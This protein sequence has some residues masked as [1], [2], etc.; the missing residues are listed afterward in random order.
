MFYFT[1]CFKTEIN[2]GGGEINKQLAFFKFMT[3]KIQ[4]DR[5]KITFREKEDVIHIDSFC[6][7]F[8]F[9]F[10]YYII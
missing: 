9:S 8:F 4:N 10:K 3:T 1:F 2:M 7:S 5:F 6:L